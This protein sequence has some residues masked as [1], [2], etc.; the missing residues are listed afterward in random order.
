[1]VRAEPIPPELGHLLLVLPPDLAAVYSSATRWWSGKWYFAYNALTGEHMGVAQDTC[2]MIA[3]AL[4]SVSFVTVPVRQRDT[5]VGRL[6][7]TRHQAFD[8]LDPAF[9]LQVIS[10]VTPVIENTRLVDRLMSNAADEARQRIA[11]DLHDSVIQPYIGLQMG[12][13]ACRRKLPPESEVNRDLDRLM[14][15]T[16]ESITELRGYV[17]RLRE[18][19]I[20]QDNLLAALHRYAARFN[21]ATGIAVEVVSPTDVRVNDQLATEVFQLVVEGLSNVRRHTD[22][23][24]AAVELWQDTDHLRLRIQNVHTNGI[25]PQPFHPRSISERATTLGGRAV[26]EQHGAKTCVSVEIPL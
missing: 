14:E 22:A 19:G 6:Y 17:H 11:R 4:E 7:L 18:G 20:H 3:A 2:A 8:R 24:Q 9:L 12:L 21:E 13:A 16:R 15:L 5:L 23:Q 1:V 25:S 26:V 10:H